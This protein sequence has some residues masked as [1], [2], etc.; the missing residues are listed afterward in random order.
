MANIGI[1][2]G[3]STGNTEAIAEDIRE[4][5]GPSEVDIFDIATAQPTDFA[6]YSLLIFGASTWGL[7]A[8][9]DDWEVMLPKLQKIDFD[10]KTIALYGLGDQD[11]YPDTFLDA[12][13][14]L[15]AF[16]AEKN[17]QIIGSWPV[18]GYIFKGS[19]ALQKGRFVGL[20]LDEDTQSELT[21]PRLKQWL[22]DIYN[23]FNE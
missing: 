11:T 10:N 17:C 21:Q 13:G 5:F 23:A 3:S 20:A 9:Q 15:Y 12:M 1:F 22:G 4:Y 8:L 2:Y 16:F 6:R 19:K 7:G 18:E 14:V